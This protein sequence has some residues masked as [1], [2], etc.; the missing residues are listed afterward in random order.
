MCGRLASDLVYTILWQKK[1]PDTF[2]VVPAPPSLF[3]LV[4]NQ[5]AADKL[6]IHLPNSLQRHVSRGEQVH[7]QGHGRDRATGPNR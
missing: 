3:D 6:R 2:G 4:V 5:T 7:A 1:S